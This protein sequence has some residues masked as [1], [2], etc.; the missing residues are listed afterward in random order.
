MHPET[1]VFLIPILLGLGFF[2]AVAFIVYVIV[3]N[4]RRGQQLKVMSEFQSRL[5]DRMGSTRELGEFLDSEG[6]A[7]FL[8]AISMER[9]HP[10]ER[11]LRSVGIGIVVTGIGVAFWLIR[12]A[13]V[14]DADARAFVGG[15][16]ILGICIGIA[17]LLTA[18]ASMRLSRSF[19]ILDREGTALRPPA[20]R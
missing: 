9:Q 18:A 19:G 13:M 2:A 8:S 14:T 6:G 3:D 20:V 5:L 15:L 17:F 4:R 12:V 16:A 7:R 10:A 11:I 1:F